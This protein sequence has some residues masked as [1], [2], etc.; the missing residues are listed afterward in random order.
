MNVT[1]TYFLKCIIRELNKKLYDS[2]DDLRSVLASEAVAAKRRVSLFCSNS[3]FPYTLWLCQV[4]AH[5]QL[6][7]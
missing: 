6:F 4:E 3:V 5:S 2:N 1:L 7:S